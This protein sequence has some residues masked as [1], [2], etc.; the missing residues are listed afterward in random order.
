MV[1]NH[2]VKAENNTDFQITQ[3]D[4]RLWDNTVKLYLHNNLWD[5]RDSADAGE[6]LMIPLISAFELNQAE[7]QKQFAS[8]FNRFMKE[9]H[10]S[11][12]TSEDD[13]DLAREGYLYLASRFV[14]LAAQHNRTELI[15][16][17]LVD[18]LQNEVKIL[19]NQKPAVWYERESFEGG[20]KERLEWKIK[21]HNVSRSYYRAI[22]DHELYLFAIAADLRTYERLTKPVE[23][24]SSIN[25]DILNMT[26]ITLRDYIK[27]TNNGGWLFQPGAWK[28]HPDYAYAG[29]KNITFNMKPIPLSDI[30]EDSSHSHRWPVWLKSMSSACVETDPK[31]KYYE[32]LEKGLEQQ[33]YEKV[34]IKPTMEFPAYKLNNYMNGNN[35]IYR[36]GYIT[37]GENNGYGP[38]E[39]SGILVCGWWGIMQ[40]ERIKMV[41][42]EMQSEFPLSQV[43]IKTYIGPNTT[44]ER[45]PYV[46]WPDY[47]TNGFGELNV[48]LSAKQYGEKL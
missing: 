47:F 36:W 33:F 30:A 14:A 18:R 37:Q 17:G 28:D 12:S 2:N 46:K 15:P 39:L 13:Y 6:A 45:N 23:R 21:T 19:W 38:S 10:S 5:K 43:V 3:Y 35:G 4:N 27:S 48:R 8:H 31:R 26:Y 22:T 32:G 42:Q 44:R 20:I 34:L 11:F 1:F 9:D 16:S 40:S 41:Y 25:S 24:W 29:N 7:W